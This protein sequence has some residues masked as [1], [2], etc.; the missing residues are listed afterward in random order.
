ME[1]N[2][3]QE[4]GT[5]KLGMKVHI[6]KLRKLVTKEKS[7]RIPVTGMLRYIVDHCRWDG[8]MAV[9]EI[10]SGD[11]KHPSDLAVWVRGCIIH[12]GGKSE[13]QTRRPNICRSSIR[14]NTSL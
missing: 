8:L 7:E 3:D 2:Y 12:H 9:G 6:E 14:S 5:I 4:K 11:A 13:V 10:S 1:L